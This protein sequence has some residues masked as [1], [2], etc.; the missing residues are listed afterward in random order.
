M[1]CFTALELPPNVRAHLEGVADRLRPIR[2]LNDAISWTKPENL[3]ITLKFLGEIPDDRVADLAN[4]FRRLPFAPLTLTLDHFLVLPGQGPARV[5]AC[6]VARD[7]KPLIHLFGQ[8][9]SAAQPL[10][11]RREGRPFKPHVTLGRFRR[12][13]NRM[14]AATLIRMVNPAL[15]PSPTFTATAYTLFQSTLTPT[16]PIYTP[17]ARILG[18]D[19]PLKSPK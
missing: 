3:H 10:G 4:A 13:S 2:S 7:V 18:T 12:P 1:R 5:L 11:V 8:I 16:G 19:E 15:L 17:L 14:T 6:N 9:E